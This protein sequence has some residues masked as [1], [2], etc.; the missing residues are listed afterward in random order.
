MSMISEAIRILDEGD[1]KLQIE[2]LHEELDQA[3]KEKNDA[4]R[5]KEQFQAINR[6]QAEELV[7]AKEENEKK[8]NLIEEL[9]RQIEH[10]RR[11]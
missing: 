5:E 10:L 6:K 4:L 9:K 8:D 1:A 3:I 7:E 2:T 11:Q